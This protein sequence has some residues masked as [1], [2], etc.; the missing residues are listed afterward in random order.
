MKRPSG[1]RRIERPVVRLICSSRPPS[2]P[3]AS[4]QAA[5]DPLIATAVAPVIFGRSA[6]VIDVRS[7]TASRRLSSSTSARRPSGV[8]AIERGAARLEIAIVATRAGSGAVVEQVDA[9]RLPASSREPFGV[10]ASNIS[11]PESEA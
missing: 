8:S 5:P 2:R 4:T 1:M 3:R 9:P 6:T 11:P 7:R 10:T